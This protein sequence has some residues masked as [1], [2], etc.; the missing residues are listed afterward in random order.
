MNAWKE[1]TWSGWGKWQGKNLGI[2]DQNLL[3]TNTIFSMNK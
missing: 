3:C 2:Y 1:M